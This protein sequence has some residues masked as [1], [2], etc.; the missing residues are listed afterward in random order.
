[1]KRD[2]IAELVEYLGCDCEGFEDEPHTCAAGKAEDRWKEMGAEIESL[3]AENA[4][5]WHV[6]D[7]LFHVGRDYPDLCTCDRCEGVRNGTVL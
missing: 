5:L 7:E 4:E 6:V 1:M 2:A 3:R